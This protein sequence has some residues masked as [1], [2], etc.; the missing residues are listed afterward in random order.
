MG[1]LGLMMTRLSCPIATLDWESCVIWVSVRFHVAIRFQ[2]LCKHQRHSFHL[3]RQLCPWLAADDVGVGLA[4]RAG[5]REPSAAD[6]V[7]DMLDDP[8]PA[9][10]SVEDAVLLEAASTAADIMVPTAEPPSSIRVAAA[11][12]AGRSLWTVQHI[13]VHESSCHADRDESICRELLV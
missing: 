6:L 1:H 3:S 11:D 8:E 13:R 7:E 10:A 2:L 5:Y 9:T 4:E 12:Q